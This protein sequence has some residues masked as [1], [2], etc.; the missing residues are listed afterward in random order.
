MISPVIKQR[1]GVL[2]C[3]QEKSEAVKI[4]PLA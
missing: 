1:G 2:F 4:L 3:S